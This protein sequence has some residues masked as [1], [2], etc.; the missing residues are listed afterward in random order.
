MGGWQRSLRSRVNTMMLRASSHQLYRIAIQNLLIGRKLIWRFMPRGRL[1]HRS[2]RGFWV[3]LAQVTEVSMSGRARGLA[4]TK[5]RFSGLF[6]EF[7][8][9]IFYVVFSAFRN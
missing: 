4:V 2:V 5:Y 9:F 6:L 8:T 7:L 3:W 1:I